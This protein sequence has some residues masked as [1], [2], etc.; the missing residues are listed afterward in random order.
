MGTL[1]IIDLSVLLG[2]GGLLILAGVALLNILQRVKVAATPTVQAILDALLPYVYRGIVA[3]E[4]LA[5]E[6]LDEID[7]ELDGTDK[8]A[9]ANGIYDTLPDIIYVLGR[10]IPVG[11]VKH[12]V[13]R[14][15]FADFVKRIYDETDAFIERNRD[16]L[17][18]QIP[19]AVG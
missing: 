17:K 14:E 19:T 15:M 6:G 1:S 12:F 11:L 16:Y 7:R 2:V 13:S 9:I 3:G 4:K 5:V 8:A 18:K 10:A